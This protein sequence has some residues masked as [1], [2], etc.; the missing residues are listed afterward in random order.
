MVQHPSSPAPFTVAL[1][2]AVGSGVVFYELGF[3]LFAN[4][5]FNNIYAIAILVTCVGVHRLLRNREL[6]RARPLREFSR[7][8]DAA[9]AWRELAPHFYVRPLSFLEAALPYHGVALYIARHNI[10]ALEI[11]R[12]YVGGADRPTVQSLIDVFERAQNEY[13]TYGEYLQ[14]HRTLYDLLMRYK[15]DGIP[16][17][18]RDTSAPSSAGEKRVQ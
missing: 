15:R 16:L 14:T 7:L 18:S 10:A 1:L 5:F 17:G 12:R 13:L 6:R 8:D 2:S 11:A 3:R 9:T 4:V